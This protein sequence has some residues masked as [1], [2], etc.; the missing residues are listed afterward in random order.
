[1][2]LH[3]WIRAAREHADLTQDQLGE[4]LERTKAMVSHWETGKNEPPYSTLLK[5]AEITGYAEPLPGVERFTGS[6]EWP[7]PSIR[8]AD[9]ENLPESV[10]TEVAN[11]IKWKLSENKSARDGVNAA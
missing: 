3:E 2:K 11:F 5:L 1:M 7:F 4:R 8:K 6:R 10:K 9:F